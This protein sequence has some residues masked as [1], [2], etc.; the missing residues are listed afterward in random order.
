MRSGPPRV[1]PPK[2]GP[3]AGTSV[4]VS[5][6]V[7]EGLLRLAVR[8][9]P[10][11]TGGV[12]Y[13]GGETGS[14]GRIRGFLE[15]RSVKPASDHYRA[16]ACEVRDEVFRS[17]GGRGLVVGMFHTH[18]KGAA[19]PSALDSRTASAGY[20]HV[21]G[22]VEVRFPRIRAFRRDAPNDPLTELRLGVVAQKEGPGAS[23]RSPTSP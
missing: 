2:A 12:L 1:N 8:R 20:I 16:D 19:S 11:E 3:T 10:Y 14:A 17:D 15:L 23:G 21:I 9:L 4:I 18:T 6:S 7:A 22:A 5:R 13:G